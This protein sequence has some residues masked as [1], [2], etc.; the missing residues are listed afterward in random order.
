MPQKDAST[1]P[2]IETITPLSAPTPKSTGPAID[3]GRRQYR[4]IFL[5]L[6]VSL[7]L[8][9]SGGGWLLYYLSQNPL[10]TDRSTNSRP[11]APVKVEKKP[12]APPQEQK[13]TEVDPAQLAKAKAN[14]EQKL[15]DFLEAR[16]N[17]AGKGV[18]EWGGALYTEMIKLGEAADSYF[19]NNEYSAASEHYVRA[20]SIAQDL[21]GRSGEAQSRLIAEGQTAL[22]AGDGSLAQRKF[23]TV[24]MIDSSNQVARRG[25]Q[26]AKTIETVIALIASGRQH[27]ESGNLSQAA[28]DYQK[29]LSLDPHSQEAGD[30]LKD[31]NT[32]IKEKQF[33]QLISEGLAAF[34]RND[35]QLARQKLIKAKSLKPKSREVL[36]ALSQVDQAIRLARIEALHRQAQAAEQIEDW[37]GALKAYLA[38]LSIDQ[39]VQFANRGKNRATEQIRTA[40]RL[41]FFL[42][43]PDTLESDGQL[44]NAILLLGEAKEVKPR[45]SKLTARITK[46]EHLV[47]IAK[48]PI[49]VTIE[50]DNF[51][52]VAVYRVGKL[53]RF[54][55]RELELRPGTYT[56]VGARD[57]Y[58]DVRQKIVVNPGRQPI[59]ITVICRVKI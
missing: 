14:A 57:G 25:L 8:L 2:T 26:R 5:I 13:P 39:N 43:K 9:V 48:T 20:T 42:A 29:A 58:Q 34:H 56:V 32:L 30:A 24:L 1:R 36:D 16:D 21:A 22:E 17:L 28:A 55:V 33:Q 12:D 38:V 27:E 11:P 50:S 44:N 6:I 45:G 3:N 15:G 35:Y 37:Q 7:V 10:Q 18:A 51:T 54:E 4:N 41:D 19:M 47:S 31:A 40:K 49:K 23:G 53:G 59:R 52:H 46:L